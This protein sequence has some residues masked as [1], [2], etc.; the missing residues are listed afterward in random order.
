MFRHMAMLFS[1]TSAVTVTL[2]IIA[3]FMLLAGNVESFTRN[4]ENDF[5]IHAIV[6]AAEEVEIDELLQQ[7]EAFPEVRSVEFSS[8]EEEYALFLDNIQSKQRYYVSEV[9]PMPDA[10]IVETKTAQDIDLVK[11]KLENLE[12]IASARY[13][14]DG[15]LVMVETFESLR[16]GIFVFILALGVLAVFLISNTIKMTI[17]TRRVEIAI[18]RNVGASNWYIRTPFVVEGLMI[19]ILGAIV[20]VL[21][22]FLGYSYLYKALNGQFFS[23]MFLLKEVNPFAVDICLILVLAGGVVG[24]LGSY[25]AVSKYLRWKR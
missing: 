16:Y 11:A 5:K 3:V 23:S 15:V 19:G 2:L 18:M 20:P 17:H 6:D 12:G 10:F 21:V 4:I 9:N 25:I 22:T 14:G 8:K 13:G 1:S 24:M 7:I